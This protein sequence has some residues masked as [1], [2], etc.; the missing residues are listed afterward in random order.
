MQT[1]IYKLPLLAS[2]LSSCCI[3]L[4]GHRVLVWQDEKFLQAMGGR[5]HHLSLSRLHVTKL[6]G[7][8]GNDGQSQSC[9]MYTFPLLKCCLNVR[10]KSQ[11]SKMPELVL[12]ICILKS[13][14]T[15]DFHSHGAE[16][17]MQP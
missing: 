10:I 14:G 15:T 2:T 9:I 17:I 7:H 1:G 8:F 6:Y 11:A 12:S 16:E 3:L 13:A 5:I 4:S